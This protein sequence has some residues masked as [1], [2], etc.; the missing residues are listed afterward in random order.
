M[1]FQQYQQFLNDPRALLN[2]NGNVSQI[3]LDGSMSSPL[4]SNSIARVIDREN[5][6]QLE[7][8]YSKS[9]VT[10]ISI[11][12][13]DNPIPQVAA[14]WISRN[15]PPAGAEF[16]ADTA[17]YLEW[18]VNR[19]LAIELKDEARLFF[20]AELTGCGILVFYAADKLIVVHHNIQVEPLPQSFFQKLFE[21]AAA[22]QQ[23][24][25][26]YVAETRENALVDLANDIVE[27]VPGITGGTS[28]S[29]NQYGGTAR[30]FGIRQAGRWRIYVNR[31]VAGQY[32]TDLLCSQP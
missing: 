20:T 5:G 23:R 18:E 30:V 22:R 15:T 17:Y 31:P 11:R 32:Q 10:Q 4:A 3:R 28:L 24:E 14:I 2:G 16:Q 25:S 8:D 13:D 6:R 21:S 12:Y 19:A 9:R 26:T 27:Q 7:Y 29:V 1:N